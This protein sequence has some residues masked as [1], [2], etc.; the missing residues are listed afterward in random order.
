M[1]EGIGKYWISWVAGPF[2]R[3][4]KGCLEGRQLPLGSHTAQSRGSMHI[5]VSVLCIWSCATQWCWAEALGVPEQ[6]ASPLHE[7]PVPSMVTLHTAQTGGFFRKTFSRKLCGSAF[8][9]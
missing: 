9:G 7:T 2:V 4:S 5:T 6:G 3:G 8:L 1:R